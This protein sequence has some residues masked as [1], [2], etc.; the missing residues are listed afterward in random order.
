M[1]PE[2]RASIVD[3]YTRG[4]G[5]DFIAYATD[6]SR[7]KVKLALNEA[8]VTIRKAGRPPGETGSIWQRRSV[9]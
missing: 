7:A 8:G 5:I 2:Q 9:P 6:I 4:Q 1:T 3:R